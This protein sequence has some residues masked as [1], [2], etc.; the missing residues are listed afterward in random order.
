MSI[1][2]KN[3]ENLTT[4]PDSHYDN[5]SSSADSF[6]LDHRLMVDKNSAEHLHFSPKSPPL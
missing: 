4:Q 1:E 3:L 6:E 5:Q 2:T